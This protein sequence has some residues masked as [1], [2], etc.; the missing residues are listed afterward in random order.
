L[1]LV[2]SGVVAV[3]LPWYCLPQHPSLAGRALLGSWYVVLA[4]VFVTA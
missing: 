4:G 2:Y 3:V 1:A